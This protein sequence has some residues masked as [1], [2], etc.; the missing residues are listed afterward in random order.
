MELASCIK[1]I[2][3]SFNCNDYFDSHAIINELLIKKEY[4]KVYLES[5]PKGCS[6]ANYHGQIAQLI[7]K[8]GLAEKVILHGKEVIVKTHT[9]YG[10][11]SSNHLWK[12]IYI[13]PS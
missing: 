7:E 12:R 3:N 8:S 10:E 4:H 13:Y 9:I 5:F 2:V 6:I 11:L 1:D